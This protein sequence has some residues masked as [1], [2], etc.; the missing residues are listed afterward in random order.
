MKG[1]ESDTAGTALA[2]VA[3]LGHGQ[4][5]LQGDYTDTVARGLHWL[6]EAE[7]YDGDLRG[8]GN[9]RMY[10][11]GQAA[12]ALC[13]AYA[14]TQDKQLADPAQRAIDYIVRAQHR[15]G[16]W[17]YEPGQAGDTSVVG[18]QLMALRHAQMAYLKV[19]TDSF[20]KAAKFLDSVQT[21]PSIGLYTYMPG[22]GTTPAMTAEGLLCRQY[23]GWKRNDSAMTGGIRWL[24]KQNPP[25]ADNV[26]MYYWYYATQ[27]MHH[28]G[29]SPWQE[30]N[31]QLARPA[32]LDARARR[33]RGRQL[34]P[35][36]SPR[37]DGGPLV[38]DRAGG[39]HARSLL[40]P[41]A[42][43]R[44]QR[45]GSERN[46]VSCS[47]V[48]SALADAVS[49][50]LRPLKRTVRLKRTLLSHPIPLSRHAIPQRRAV[51]LLHFVEIRHPQMPVLVE[52]L[53]VR[54]D[55]FQRQQ[56][57]EA[58]HA[59]IHDLGNVVDRDRA[60]AASDDAA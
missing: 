38:H 32:G 45:A 55:F 25:R 4:T 6:V 40:P 60:S 31:G 51:L 41:P 8:R 57:I 13:E 35:A 50:S 27:V 22:G 20:T 15:R 48:G 17:R 26:N 59:G 19:P 21:Q 24:L 33:P 1:N 54:H 49:A 34:E 52:I 36:R 23:S 7:G 5:H 53:D 9:G 10:A 37:H 43:V 46:K 16:G 11:H 18:W 12:I 30:W 44:H 28:V 42:A 58:D 3:V 14:L 29:G 56:R 39:L 47:C 2:H